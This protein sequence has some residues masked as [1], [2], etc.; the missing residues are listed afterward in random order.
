MMAIFTHIYLKYVIHTCIISQGRDTYKNIPYI[1][2]YVFVTN[3][4][5]KIKKIFLRKMPKIYAAKRFDSSL[6]GM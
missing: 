1:C 4:K 2:T 3:D 5:M 6:I